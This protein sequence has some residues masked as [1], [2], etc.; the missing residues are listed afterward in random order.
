[1]SVELTPQTKKVIAHFFPP[2]KASAVEQLL[3]DE[4]GGNLPLYLPSTPEGLE[5]VRFAVLKISSGNEDKLLEVISLAR[6]DW[7]DVLVW[8]GFA[9][10]IEAHNKWLEGL[11]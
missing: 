3:V 2:S 9:N 8:A 7:R 6:R 4:C 10:D 5:R 1:M 11:Q